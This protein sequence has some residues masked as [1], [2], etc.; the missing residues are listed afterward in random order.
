MPTFAHSTTRFVRHD[1]VYTHTHTHRGTS[2]YHD[3]RRRCDNGLLFFDAYSFHDD[4][5]RTRLFRRPVTAR[6]ITGHGLIGLNNGRTGL[7]P[8]SVVFGLDTVVRRIRL[9]DAKPSVRRPHCVLT[10]QIDVY[11]TRGRAPGVG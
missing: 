6:V 5:R 4:N 10:A 3:E 8:K 11:V 2:D 1:E 7:K 9:D